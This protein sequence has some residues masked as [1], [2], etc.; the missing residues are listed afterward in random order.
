MRDS[1]APLFSLALTV[2]LAACARLP[3]PRT[4][5]P[6]QA[7]AA[8]ADTALGRLALAA[9]PDRDLSGYRLMPGGDNALAAR[10]D[11]LGSW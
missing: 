9:Q 5:P 10:P 7:L 4:Q 1:H 2:L 3:P 6:T 8:S 11:R